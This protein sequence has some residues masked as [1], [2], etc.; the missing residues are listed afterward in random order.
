MFIVPLIMLTGIALV[1][2]ILILDR[3]SQATGTVTAVHRVVL[4]VG[5]IFA[6]LLSIPV[7][8]ILA[9]LFALFSGVRL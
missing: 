5:A 8:L 9:Y 7:V 6:A 3:R 2:L 1:A 4:W